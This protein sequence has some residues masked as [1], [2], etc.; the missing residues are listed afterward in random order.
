MRSVTNSSRLYLRYLM[1]AYL[2]PT[3]ALILLGGV[4]GYVVYKVLHQYRRSV[5]YHG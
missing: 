3:L 4:A 5:A 1:V 2:G